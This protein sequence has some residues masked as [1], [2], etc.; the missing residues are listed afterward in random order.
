MQP[1]FQKAATL[2][3]I[4]NKVKG[5]I[6]TIG[7]L[8]FLIVVFYLGWTFGKAYQMVVIRETIKRL[9]KHGKTTVDE[10]IIDPEE[11]TKEEVILLSSEEINDTIL[12]YDSITNEF[13]CQGKTLEE[14]AQNFHNRKQN[15]IGAIIHNN[16]ELLFM[17]GKI[18]SVNNTK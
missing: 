6:M 1:L 9:A 18:S 12:I 14:A 5:V 2:P 7:D 11:V 17:N 8:L 13:I 4:I 15:T 3:F 10:L 16:N